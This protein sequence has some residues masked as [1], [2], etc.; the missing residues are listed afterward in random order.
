MCVYAYAYGYVVHMDMYMWMYMYKY[1]RMCMC[2][3]LPLYFWRTCCHAPWMIG[4]SR[5]RSRQQAGP[6]RILNS[7]LSVH[8]KAK[9]S[10]NPAKKKSSR[11]GFSA[12]HF[13]ADDFWF[14]TGIDGDRTSKNA[15]V[16]KCGKNF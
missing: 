1:M 4:N 13:L 8:A 14:M 9:V 2:V 12:P 11:S 6:E 3:S 15:N 16:K 10:Q 5:I 7:H